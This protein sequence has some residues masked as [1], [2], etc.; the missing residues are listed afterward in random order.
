MMQILNYDGWSFHKVKTG[1][2]NEK[3]KGKNYLKCF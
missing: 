2:F 1:N 3:L